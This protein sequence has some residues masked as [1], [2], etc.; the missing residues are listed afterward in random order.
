MKK[1]EKRFKFKFISGNTSNII[2]DDNPWKENYDEFD[3][4]IIF[5]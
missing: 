2:C 5:S 4:K 3:R 1:Q